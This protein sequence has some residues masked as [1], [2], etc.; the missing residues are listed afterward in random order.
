MKAARFHRFGGPEVLAYEDVPDPE[1]GPGD[2]LICVRAVGVNHVDLD[3]REG[4]SRL[5]ITLPHILGREVAGEIVAI[6]DAASPFKEGDRVWVTSR[7]PCYNCEYCLT[8]RDNL[9]TNGV[10][11]GVHIPG[12]YAELLKA[13]A[14]S[15]FPLP[16]HASFE[17]AA[18]SQIAFGTAWHVLINRG[19]LKAGQ[20]ALIHAAGSGI[21]SAAIQVARLAGAMVFATASTDQKLGRARHLG[22]HHL[23]NY[24]REDF[25]QKVLD[26]TDGLGVDLVM[27]HIGGEVFSKSLKCLKNDGVMVTVGGHGGEEVPFDIVPFFRQELRLIGSRGATLSELKTVMGLVFEGSLKPVIHGT[28][29]LAQASEAHRVVASREIFGKALLLP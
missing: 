27:E 18:A 20:M 16:D 4:V 21:G 5:P 19:A 10:Q 15:L 13:P 24:N 29:P 2:A 6:S 3:M 14:S 1:P 25:A 23:I 9:C 17:D 12:G 11:F 7:P 26:L 28:F 22:A 8:G